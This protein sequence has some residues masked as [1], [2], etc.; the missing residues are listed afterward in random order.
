M[1]RIDTSFTTVS[2]VTY[3]WLQITFMLFGPYVLFS[4]YNAEKPKELDTSSLKHLFCGGAAVPRNLLIEMRKLLPETFVC[5]VYGQTETSGFITYF[6]HEDPEDRKLS[7]LKPDSCGR[8]I[9]NALIKVICLL[10]THKTKINCI[11]ISVTVIV[12]AETEKHDT[13]SVS[14]LR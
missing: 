5:P 4:L 2:S 11:R 12:T 7:S 1:L 10:Y 9:G 3:F 6:N 8:P 14:Y 13:N